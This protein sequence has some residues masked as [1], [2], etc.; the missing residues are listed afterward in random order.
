MNNPV[1]KALT[2]VLALLPSSAPS[3]QPSA[4][5]GLPAGYSFSC[6]GASLWRDDGSLGAKT[7]VVI[8]DG[9]PQYDASAGV[10]L[11]IHLNPLTWA[12]CALKSQN[13]RNVVV[14]DPWPKQNQKIGTLY[15][16]LASFQPELLPWLRVVALQDFGRILVHLFQEGESCPASDSQEP[17]RDEMFEILSAQIREELT[18]ESSRNDRHAI[19]NIIGPMVLLGSDYLATKGVAEGALLRVFEATG[20]LPKELTDGAQPSNKI[21]EESWGNQPLRLLLVDDQADCGWTD[22]V[23]AILPV[24]N[25][26]LVTLQPDDVITSPDAVLDRLM[27]EWGLM[28]DAKDKRFALQLTASAGGKDPADRQ[29]VLLLDL[30]LHSMR[31][32]ENE[33]AF[34]KKLLPL[35]ERFKSDGKAEPFAWPGFSAQEIQSVQQWCEHP[36]RETPEHLVALSLLPRLI[37]LL[38]VSQPIII[39]SSTGQ[40]SLIEK[41]KPYGNI[42]TDFEK[43]RFFGRDARNVIAETHAKFAASV[44]RAVKLAVTRRLSQ[45]MT[46]NVGMADAAL[47][48]C[49]LKNAGSNSE[50]SAVLYIDESGSARELTLGGILLLLPR[51]IS[52]SEV[53]RALRA[54]FEQPSSQGAPAVGPSRS[55]G[56]CHKPGNLELLLQQIK[57][58]FPTVHICFVSLS[59]GADRIFDDFAK[60]DELH[61]ERVADNLWREIF[62]RLVELAIYAIPSCLVENDACLKSFS[63]RAPTRVLPASSIGK[64]SWKQRALFNRWGID[65]TLVGPDA[66]LWEAV[67]T[68]EALP[69]PKQFKASRW[70][71]LVKLLH[72]LKPRKHPDL[73]IRY[74]SFDSPR[75]V[76]EEVMRLYRNIES[77]PLAEVVRGFLL[78]CHGRPAAAHIP[79]LHFA[80]DGFLYQQNFRNVNPLMRVTGYYGRNL[81]L[82][83]ESN[84]CTANG[85]R[86]GAIL[87]ASA[88][89]LRSGDQIQALLWKRIGMTLNAIDGPDFLRFSYLANAE[90]PM[91]DDQA[92]SWQGKVIKKAGTVGGGTSTGYWGVIEDQRG[93]QVFAPTCPADVGDAVTFRPMRDKCPGEIIAADVKKI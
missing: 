49:A 91:S 10:N 38:D 16:T 21:N 30:R 54:T 61:D 65:V 81:E 56:W 74:F 34:I 25:P 89:E 93:K 90:T 9:L 1:G 24:S 48:G 17:N 47:A 85:N 66:S 80:V 46:L 92:V 79:I 26:S 41:F 68:I 83:L 33:A 40:R 3:Q 31:S 8:W 11:G 88:A 19:Q 6:D 70:S 5:G 23:R 29:P 45:Q 72:Q 77:P 55:K 32:A 59:A 44:E 53:D 20:L 50:W 78:N 7:L 18:R 15:R 37:A 63:I 64:D 12:I 86:V 62:R 4:A 52:E 42:I 73:M 35:C 84:R 87:S 13:V 51:G 57:K 39:F 28:G 36:K 60:H 71:W 82:L 58:R 14:V 2:Q 22:W 67:S 43:P 69:P 75:P 27:V 76:V